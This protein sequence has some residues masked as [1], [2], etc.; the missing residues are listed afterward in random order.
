MEY[1]YQIDS[2]RILNKHPYFTFVIKNI[3][4][5]QLVE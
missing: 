1:L 5:K 4:S 2:K 3:N